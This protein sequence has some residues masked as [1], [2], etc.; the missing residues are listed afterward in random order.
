MQIKISI[1]C[2]SKHC[3]KCKRMILF[4]D[5]SA[6]N[7]GSAISSN[8]NINNAVMQFTNNTFSEN[9]ITS[10]NGEGGTV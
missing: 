6:V 5:N 10:P 2:P 8:Y 3:R 9:T 1:L 4:V 7:D